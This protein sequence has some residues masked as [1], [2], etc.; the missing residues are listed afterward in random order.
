MNPKL[1][2]K[3]TAQLRVHATVFAEVVESHVRSWVDGQL[4]PDPSERERE[5]LT[6]ALTDPLRALLSRP[7]KLFRARFVETA[8]DAAGGDS[9][10]MP[11]ALPVIVEA[12]HAGSLI[13]DDIQ[14]NSHERRG[15]PCL[16]RKFGTPLAI[17]TGNL[18]Y[19]FALDLI[20]ELGLGDGEQLTLHREA[21]R[22]LLGGHQGQALDLTARAPEL[23]RAE[24]IRLVNCSTR[25]KAG[26]LLELAGHLGAVGA[27][28][29]ATTR[30][31]LAKFGCDLGVGLQ[32]LDDVSG[33]FRTERRVKARED[34][35]LGRPTWAWALLAEHASD[36]VF[37]SCRRAGADALSDGDAEACLDL[38][39]TS[40]EPI[41]RPRIHKYLRAAL[42]ELRGW[43]GTQPAYLAI[44]AEVDRLEDSFL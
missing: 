30:Q 12:I 7:G 34:L 13:V 24:L 2:D 16:H 17:N 36:S 27:G 3:Q 42:A 29:D 32:M 21:S 8:F 26:S 44:E 28:S 14:D 38:F 22:A 23:D 20:G 40:L 31:R 25:L 33:L 19:C 6:A 41:A 1:R 37:E 15:L 43:T 5:V 39:A 10:R 11:K 18:L 35:C 9:S 4:I